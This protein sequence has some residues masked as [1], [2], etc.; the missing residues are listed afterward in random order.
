MNMS[1]RDLP[2]ERWLEYREDDW[3][4]DCKLLFSNMGRVKSFN[5]NKTKG[6][7][8]KG[9]LLNGY[10]TFSATRKS[11]KGVTRYTHKII[12]ILFAPR[13]EAQVKVIHNDYKKTNNKALNLTWATNKEQIDHQRNHPKGNA[14]GKGNAKLT[15]AKVRVLKKILRD[16]ERK[17]RIKMLSKQFGITEMQ[18]W[19]IKT[20]ENWG[21][22][23]I[24]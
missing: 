16:P 12:A 5:V 14:M 19:R 8:I 7:I 23:K 15:E 9:G 1:I 13:K 2:G 3:K 11:G 18:L 21:H 4:D 10:A 22:I 17:T 24:D 20:G 6:Q